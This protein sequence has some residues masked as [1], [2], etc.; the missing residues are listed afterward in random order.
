MGSGASSPNELV[1]EDERQECK[2]ETSGS[3]K[4]RCTE[5]RA[6]PGV[7]STHTRV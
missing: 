3:V 6:V 2:S 4:P 5:Q 1:D 7:Q